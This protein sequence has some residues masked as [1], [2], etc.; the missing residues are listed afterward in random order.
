MK[1]HPKYMLFFEFKG[2]FQSKN[3]AFLAM[4]NK[5]DSLNRSV[6]AKTSVTAKMLGE[7][8]QNQYIN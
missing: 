6:T 4:E 2:V 1:R 3:N 7:S 8:Y 5:F